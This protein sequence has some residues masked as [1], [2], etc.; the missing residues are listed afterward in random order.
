[1]FLPL[2]H[3]FARAISFGAFDAK[4]T[5]AH[6]SDLTTL[7]EQFAGFKPNFILSVP[8][9]VFEKVY[10]SARQKA[11]D[12]G[13][14]SIFDKAAATAIEYSESLE[15]GGP[16]GLALKLKHA[17]F[18]KL[19]YSKLRAALGGECERAV[20]GG[21][22]S[23]RASA[24][25]SAASASRSTRLRTHGDQ[26]RNH[27][28]HLER[29]A[30]R[31]RRQADQRPCSTDRR[32]RRTPPAGPGRVRRLLAQ[33]EGHCRIHR[34]RLVPHRRPRL[35]RQRGYVSI[36]GRKK[37]II[38]TAGGKNV[39]P[40]GLEDSLRAH[41][42]ISQCLV[43]GDGQPFIGALITLDPE[44]LPVGS[45]ATACPP[46]PPIADLV[47]NADLIAEIDSA[48]ADANKKVSNPEQ[49]KK[50]TILEVDFTQETGELTPTLKLKRNII[51]EAHKTKISD[52]YA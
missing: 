30:R 51:H 43:V 21:A 26:R 2:A 25:T 37:E 16:P 6:T 13:K 32:G 11:V 45:N 47:K 3:V 8:P 12:G 24:T 52:L 46:A 33:R 28:Q 29:A 35:D 44:T 42:L 14:G 50:Y 1:M 9:R 10:N 48:V 40:A 39:A 27:R 23:A 18:D 19:V 31:H 36:T 5:V 20:S 34:R 15:K 17:V 41:A 49:I 22:A 7:L 38:V 4:V